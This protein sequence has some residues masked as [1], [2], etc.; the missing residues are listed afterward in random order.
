M[1]NGRAAFV[2]KYRVP[3]ENATFHLEFGYRSGK[4][5]STVVGHRGRAWI[6]R[7]TL[8]V[9]RLEQAAEIPRDFPLKTSNTT[10]E[11]SWTDI[12]GRTWLLPARA[13]VIMGTREI[14]T[15]NEV[16]FSD[17]RKFAADSSVVFEDPT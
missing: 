12:A 15:R 8:Q 14:L 3:P 7:E 6:D 10:L 1:L 13:S 9:V 4:P 17:F 16:E 11:Y 5:Q 2:F